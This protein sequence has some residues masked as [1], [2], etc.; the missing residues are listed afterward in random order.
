M[1]E[2][3][4]ELGSIRVDVYKGTRL[5]LSCTPIIRFSNQAYSEAKACP[6]FKVLESKASLGVSAFTCM[7]GPVRS[8][9]DRRCA[10]EKM[11]WVC[12]YMFRYMDHRYIEACGLR[13]AKDLVLPHVEG[14]VT[15]PDSDDEH[16][17]SKAEEKLERKLRERF[18]IDLFQTGEVRR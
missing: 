3:S 5:G 10:F 17:K 7:Y 13:P 6:D 4:S 16:P 1:P 9:E 12:R 11:T 15:V 18:P 8:K 2:R 14:V